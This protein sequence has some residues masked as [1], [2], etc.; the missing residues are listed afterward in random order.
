MCCVHIDCTPP[1]HSYYKRQ[2]ML[3]RRV[4]GSLI[5]IIIINESFPQSLC[6]AASPPV[7]GNDHLPRPRHPVI[8][9]LPLRMKSRPISWRASALSRTV[10]LQ[11]PANATNTTHARTIRS[12]RSCARTAWC[13]TIIVHNKRS[14]T[15]HWTSTARKGPPYVSI[16]Y[17]Q[18][19]FSISCTR[20]ARIGLVAISHAK[21]SYIIIEYNN[22]KN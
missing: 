12:P 3:D 7:V 4:C 18:F 2:Q 11:T 1:T 15:F 9:L 10:S 6:W 14:V 17:A 20:D 22:H 13:S 16:Y 21:I 5:I 19:I 8:A